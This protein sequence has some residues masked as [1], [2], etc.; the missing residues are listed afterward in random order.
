MNVRV[1]C[2]VACLMKNILIY[3][4]PGSLPQRMLMKIIF[5]IVPLNNRIAK[6]NGQSIIIRSLWFY[7]NYINV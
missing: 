5:Y 4:F 2:Y 7:C 3:D 1:V 6:L